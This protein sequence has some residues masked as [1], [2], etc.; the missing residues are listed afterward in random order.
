MLR[1][2]EES[3]RELELELAPPLFAL[4]GPEVCSLPWDW[5]RKRFS[6]SSLRRWA[7]VLSFK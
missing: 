7:N 6:Q 3:F 1:E 5:P 4:L 2:W